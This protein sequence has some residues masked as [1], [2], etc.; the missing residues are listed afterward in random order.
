MMT[1]R[2]VSDIT[3]ECVQGDI[4]DQN[5]IDAVVNA[6][7][8]ELRIGRRRGR[9]HPPGRGSGSGNRMPAARAP[10]GR[11]RRS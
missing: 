10:S 7:N 8:A 11:A 2:S 6:A 4:A 3:I 9:R 1:R 5:D